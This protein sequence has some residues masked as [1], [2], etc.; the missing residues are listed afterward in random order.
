MTNELELQHTINE[1]TP[2]KIFN[3]VREKVN[4]VTVIRDCFPE[5]KM[6][7]RGVG[8]CSSS[9]VPNFIS[10]CPFCGTSESKCHFKISQRKQIFHCLDCHIG[11]D[12]ISFICKVKDKTQ[13]ESLAYLIHKYKLD[14]KND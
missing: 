11:G 12:A 13:I 1:L 8:L 7:A 5:M 10:L 2:E 3:R 6:N 4:I 14:W 9:D